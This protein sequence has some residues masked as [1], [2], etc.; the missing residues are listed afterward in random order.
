MKKQRFLILMLGFFLLVCCQN[1]NQNLTNLD[2]DSFVKV[3]TELDSSEQMYVLYK[4]IKD[5][6]RQMLKYYWDNGRVQ[7]ISYFTNGLK[8]GKWSQYFENGN[9]SFTGEYSN[10]KKE[11]IHTIFHQNG[12]IAITEV[13]DRG[14]PIGIW[15]YYDTSGYLLKEETVNKKLGR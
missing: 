1:S 8:T 12:K 6:S 11:G 3:T 10:D 2:N 15:S 5:T 9:I 13:Y 7:A 14:E 4:S